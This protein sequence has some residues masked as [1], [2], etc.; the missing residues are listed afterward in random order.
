[1]S[2]ALRWGCDVCAPMLRRC[3]DLIPHAIPDSTLTSTQQTFSVLPQYPVTATQWHPE[4]NAFEWARHLDIPHNKDA[5][6]V[7]EAVANFIV[8]EARGCANDPPGGN[9]PVRAMCT[10]RKLNQ[11]TQPNFG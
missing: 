10:Q 5:I 9:G 6:A 4:K 3:A 7:T 2:A 11:T 1:M 8:D